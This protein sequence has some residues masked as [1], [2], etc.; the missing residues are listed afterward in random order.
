MCSL[1]KIDF[2]SPIFNEWE[3]YTSDFDTNLPDIVCG[4]QARPLN[5]TPIFNGCL[6]DTKVYDNIIDGSE[7]DDL[8]SKLLFEK[9][10]EIY[11]IIKEM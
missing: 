8:N 6:E 11:I 9:E 1:Y 10:K 3:E 4:I 2:N 5:I 7:S